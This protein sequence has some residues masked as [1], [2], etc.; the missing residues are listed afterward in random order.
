M[1]AIRRFS[2]SDTESDVD[3][4]ADEKK[5]KHKVV[6]CFHEE[7]PVGCALGWV[8]FVRAEVAYSVLQV[9]GSQPL[10]KIRSETIHEP[11]H[12]YMKFVSYM[13]TESGKLSIR[14]HPHSQKH[15]N[16]M[17]FCLVYFRLVVS[18][19]IPF[20]F[21]SRYATSSSKVLCW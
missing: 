17:Q 3:H 10:L 12:T 2:E 9:M 14:V 7:L 15:G 6:N 13:V 11:I 5:L 18:A 16:L 8:L 20:K 1:A 21:V 19:N 4:C